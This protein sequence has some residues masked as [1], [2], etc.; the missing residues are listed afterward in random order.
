MV[1]I[2]PIERNL[3]ENKPELLILSLIFKSQHNYILHT[4]LIFKSINH[5]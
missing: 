3:E 5:K 4:Q 1:Y 2:E